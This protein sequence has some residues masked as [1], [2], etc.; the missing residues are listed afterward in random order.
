[1]EE[2]GYEYY[3]YDTYMR[4]SDY[5]HLREML[6]YEPVTLGQDKYAVQIKER[7][8]PFLDDKIKA[9]A[10]DTSLGEL[11]LDEIYTIPFSQNGNNGADYLIIV[12]DEAAAGMDGYFSELAVSTEGKAP[13]DLQQT[14]ETIRLKK[15]GVPDAGRILRDAGARRDTGRSLLGIRN[16]GRIRNRPDRKLCQRRSGAGGH[17]DGSEAGDVVFGISLGVCRTCISMCGAYDHVSPAAQ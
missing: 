3:T 8:V 12:P 7:M 10:L 6:G 11:T 2:D 17:W 1:M 14:L 13:S 4:I 5:N 15:N 9:R 16:D